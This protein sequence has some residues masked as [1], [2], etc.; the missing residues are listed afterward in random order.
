MI[1]EIGIDGFKAA[2]PENIWYN[3]A[4][5]CTEYIQ[6]NT[7]T[8]TKNPLYWDT[9]AKLFDSVTVK[10]VESVDT[11]YQLYTTGEIDRVDLSES[12]LTTIYNNESDPLHDQ[13]VEKR[14]TKFS[15]QSTLTMISITMIS[16]RIPTGTP[17]LQTKH[18]VS[19]G[20]MVL[21]LEATT[22]EPTQSIRTNAT[23]TATPCRA[24]YTCRMVLSTPAWF[25]RS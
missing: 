20:T 11:A 7:K 2:T 21:I 24:L 8:L 18:S 19:A 23:T 13:L 22:R 3:G 16:P 14:P 15:Y 9:D 10:M 25:R 6:Q 17:L 12:N 4:Y 1:D 5:T